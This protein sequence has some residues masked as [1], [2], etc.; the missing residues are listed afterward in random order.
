MNLLRSLNP[1]LWASDKVID[2]L[3]AKMPD[4]LKELQTLFLQE[5][6]KYN[7]F[8]LDNSQFARAIAPR[9]SAIAGVTDFTYSGVILSTPMTSVRSP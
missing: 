2:D 6:K 5:A 7:V 3:A 1:Q 9:P 4:K 8:P